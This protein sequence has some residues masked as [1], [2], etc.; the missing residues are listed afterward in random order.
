MAA[1]IAIETAVGNTVLIVVN[2]KSGADGVGR[3]EG[4]LYRS[5]MSTVSNPQVLLRIR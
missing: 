4:I 5:P 1:R 3:L 2:E